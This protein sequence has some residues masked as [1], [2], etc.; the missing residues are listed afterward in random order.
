MHM[1]KCAGQDVSIG[2]FAD[3]L[4]FMQGK[5]SGRRSCSVPV[6]RLMDIA[7]PCPEDYTMFLVATYKCVKGIGAR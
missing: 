3:V 4:D 7:H 5:C 2:C 1:G 6:R